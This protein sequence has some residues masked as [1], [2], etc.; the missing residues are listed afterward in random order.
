M[1][2]TPGVGK[3]AFHFQLLQTH[4]A[5]HSS[6]EKWVSLVRRVWEPFGSLQHPRALK[7]SIEPTEDGW[8]VRVPGR[9]PLPSDDPWLLLAH[10]ANVLE[11]RALAESPAVHS[12]HAAAV[13]R[14]GRA[15]LLP[16]TGGAGKSSITLELLRLGWSYLSDDLAPILRHNG[17]IIPFPKA[18][19]IKD[20]DRWRFYAALWDGVSGWPPPPRHFFCVPPAMLGSIASEQMAPRFVVFPRFERRSDL[21]LEELSPAQALTLTSQHVNP[22]VPESLR[23]LAR[24][25]N[26]TRAAA[27]TFGDARAA[28]TLLDRWVRQGTENGG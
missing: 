6:D 13:A 12:L 9:S 5:F 21:V 27:L 15:L 16:G 28:A 25:C 17:R 23:V 26:G 20:P 11:E 2:E 18:L 7:V 4:V 1:R 14:R 10:L 19:G 3:R 22:L 8:R 24:M